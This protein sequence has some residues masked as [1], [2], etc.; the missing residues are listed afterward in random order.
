MA[1]FLGESSVDRCFWKMLLCLSTRKIRLFF[2]F[3]EN[4]ESLPHTMF[5]VGSIQ[6]SG[7]LPNTMTLCW[8]DH[9]AEHMGDR[10]S[11][12][13]SFFVARCLPTCRKDVTKTSRYSKGHGTNKVDRFIGSFP[14]P[15]PWILLHCFFAK[16]SVEPIS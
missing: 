16:L 13:P 7:S 2:W 5:Q 8:I 3:F 1:L 14:R 4:V 9:S 6:L 15:R 11:I 10:S 12:L